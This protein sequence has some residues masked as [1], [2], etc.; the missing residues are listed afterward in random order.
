M[1]FLSCNRHQVENLII[2]KI[3]DR[4]R[5]KI[6]DVQYVWWFKTEEFTHEL[7]T[8]VTNYDDNIY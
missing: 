7:E 3:V 1:I 8:L 4:A 6:K 5:S 2:A